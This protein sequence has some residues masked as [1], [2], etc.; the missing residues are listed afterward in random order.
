M[1]LWKKGVCKIGGSGGGSSSSSDN[2]YVV[3]QQLI[4]NF[5][6]KAN[7]LF[8]LQPG[9][10]LDSIVVQF[11]QLKKE[12]INSD[13][14]W[15]FMMADFR[16]VANILSLLDAIDIGS[17]ENLPDVTRNVKFCQ[18][19]YHTTR[20]WKQEKSLGHFDVEKWVEFLYPQPKDGTRQ[21]QN[22]CGF[23]CLKD[24]D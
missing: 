22:D 17:E 18:K 20:C 8:P 12:I 5:F 19:L 16:Y 6:Q 10:N 15:K 9:T 11:Y 2:H 7:D 13:P 4:K 3:R 21:V 1:I 24:L 14:N 23:V